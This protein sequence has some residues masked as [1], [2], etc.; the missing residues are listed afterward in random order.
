MDFVYDVSAVNED[1]M[2][3]SRSEIAGTMHSNDEDMDHDGEGGGLQLI[4]HRES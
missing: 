1:D 3:G 2:N 4:S